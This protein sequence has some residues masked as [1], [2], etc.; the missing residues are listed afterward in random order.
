MGAV[1][2]NERSVA[3]ERE[4]AR[5]L[6]YIDFRR[7]YEAVEVGLPVG[8]DR[9]D[10][11]QRDLGALANKYDIRVKNDLSQIDLFKVVSRQF[12]SLIK[13]LDNDGDAPQKSSAPLKKLNALSSDFADLV[14]KYCGEKG[15][16]LVYRDSI[17]LKTQLDEMR[18]QAYPDYKTMCFAA[19]AKGYTGLVCSLVADWG[20]DLGNIDAFVESVGD[21]CLVLKTDSKLCQNLLNIALDA[22]EKFI[23]Q[24]TGGKEEREF[25]VA[26]YA[27]KVGLPDFASEHALKISL[28]VSNQTRVE[29]LNL[30]AGTLEAYG[31]SSESKK[32]LRQTQITPE[33]GYYYAIAHKQLD[34][35]IQTA[36]LSKKQA[37]WPSISKV[38][39]KIDDSKLAGKLYAI[40]LKNDLIQP[41]DFTDNFR[42]VIGERLTRSIFPN[43]SQGLIAFAERNFETPSMQAEFLKSIDGYHF[44]D[45]IKSLL[46][47]QEKLDSQKCQKDF[48]VLLASDKENAAADA[49]AFVKNPENL[50][51]LQPTSGLQP[52]ERAGE[53]SAELLGK[54]LRAANSFPKALSLFKKAVEFGYT[55]SGGNRFA[56]NILHGAINFTAG[57]SDQQRTA[58]LS[59]LV[60]ETSNKNV[61]AYYNRICIAA[62]L[63]NL[64]D[65]GQF[66]AAMELIKDNHRICTTFE[67]D[68][69]LKNSKVVLELAKAFYKKA[70]N[71]NPAEARSKVEF[72]KTYLEPENYR[73]VLN[74]T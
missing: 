23:N 31:H 10:S 17:A 2:K 43:L 14:E 47:A 9:F 24:H 39:A 4:P 54:V 74:A 21:L 13:E 27:A 6:D 60:A 3:V 7:I 68:S 29:R 48:E 11:L 46:A 16:A 37:A 61:S 62:A 58:A 19:A 42:T 55:R 73:K 63:K 51:L 38:I 66:D 57:M 28:N 56:E 30:V 41:K 49:L 25:L 50:K 35:V 44:G 53:P 12:V 64:S 26:L 18:V 5:A 59:T 20:K 45:S 72:F 1:A 15:S 40:A 22:S 69:G 36:D 52:W 32:F 71:D 70:L 8:S 34:D 33:N 65:S 67:S